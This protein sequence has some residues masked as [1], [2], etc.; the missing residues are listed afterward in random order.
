M[1]A[2]T[3]HKLFSNVDSGVLYCVDEP[4]ILRL[5]PF[6]PSHLATQLAPIPGKVSVSRHP[7]TS[8]SNNTKL[9]LLGV[10]TALSRC[11]LWEGF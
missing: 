3:S 1:C 5:P 10:F 4:T 9:L 6:L 7:H 8:I 11:L 2:D